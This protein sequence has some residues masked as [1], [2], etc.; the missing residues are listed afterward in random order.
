MTHVNY[1]YIQ[2]AQQK[3]FWVD[4]TMCVESLKLT[5]ST[6]KILVPQSRGNIVLQAHMLEK[7]PLDYSLLELSWQ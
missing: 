7:T 5:T 3:S 6:V 1:E 4:P 2:T